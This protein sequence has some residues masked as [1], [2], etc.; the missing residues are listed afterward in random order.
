[1]EMRRVRPDTVLAEGGSSVPV[2]F[3]VVDGVV[4]ATA[5][6]NGRPTNIRSFSTGDLLGESVLLERKPWPATYAV[7]EEATLFQLDREGLEEVMV[8]NED[9]VAFLSVMRQQQ[10]DRNVSANIQ[11]LSR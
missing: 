2:M 6:V 3:L 4:E 10:N 1:M 11:K 9:P 7:S 8:G 5:L